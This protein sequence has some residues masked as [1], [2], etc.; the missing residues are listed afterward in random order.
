M[1]DTNECLIYTRKLLFNGALLSYEVQNEISKKFKYNSA[2]ARKII[3]RFVKKGLIFRSNGLIFKNGSFGLS[4]END[5][6]AF[7]CLLEANKTYLFV[8]LNLLLAG[9]MYENEIIKIANCSYNTQ[10]RSF[11]KVINE[12]KLFYADLESTDN[13]YYIKS[14]ISDFNKEKYIYIAKQTKKERVLIAIMQ[15]HNCSNL[16]NNGYYYANR[17]GFSPNFMGYKF[18]GVAF[19]Q[20]VCKNKERCTFLYDIDIVL[21]YSLN[22]AKLFYEKI[23]NV[24]SSC[25]NN[26]KCIGVIVCGDI[27]QKEKDPFLS[28]IKSKGLIYIKTASLLGA[29]FEYILGKLEELDNISDNC[30]ERTLDIIDDI[31]NKMNR[32]PEENLGNLKGELFEFIVAS[33]V[34][35]ILKNN[36]SSSIRKFVSNNKNYEIDYLVKTNDN[37]TIL[38]ESKSSKIKVELGKYDVETKKYTPD[39]VLKFFKVVQEYEKSHPSENIKFSF[40]AANGFTNEAQKYLKKM[41][42]KYISKNL[43]NF[44]TIDD[45]DGHLDNEMLLLISDWKKF[46]I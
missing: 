17:N 12:I 26:E 11:K 27:V 19:S 10:K 34:N 13:I 20:S 22:R 30:K 29:N 45:L 2:N 4:N 39:T 46:Y 14:K 31:G 44:C 28:Y 40:F 15:N 16:I 33:I 8:L 21:P 6:K 25:K 32:I 37:E 1:I 3:S 9:P 5:N 38:V 35:L 7:Y 23:S 18:D 24:I 36:I 42:K 41:D 43:R